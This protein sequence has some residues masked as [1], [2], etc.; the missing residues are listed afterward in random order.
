MIARAGDPALQFE[1]V[2]AVLAAAADEMRDIESEL[3]PVDDDLDDDVKE[4]LRPVVEHLQ[5][6][7]DFIHRAGAMSD[8]AGRARGALPV[9]SWW[10]VL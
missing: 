10:H 5:A 8:S 2:A 9:S 3:P 7:R 4:W 6:L 1:A